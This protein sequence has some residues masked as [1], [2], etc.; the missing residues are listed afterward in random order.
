MTTLSADYC[1][2]DSDDG[3]LVA[4][5]FHPPT[6]APPLRAAVATAERNDRSDKQLVR[7]ESVAER[8]EAFVPPTNNHTDSSTHKFH[9]D[10]RH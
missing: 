5:Y 3:R 4:P 10:G 8:A 2:S 9:G 1:S 6:S 7:A